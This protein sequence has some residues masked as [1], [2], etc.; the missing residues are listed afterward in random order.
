MLTLNIAVK[1]LAGPV[2]IPEVTDPKPN[3]D[4]VFFTDFSWFQSFQENTEIL[5][6]R[7]PEAISST[8]FVILVH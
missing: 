1:W 6:Q 5:I 2:V 8:T 3:P 4:R 7:R